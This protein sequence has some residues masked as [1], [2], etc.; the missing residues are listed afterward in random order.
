MRGS[1]TMERVVLGAV[2]SFL[3][4]LAV[5]HLLEPEFD[6]SFH[7][8]SEYELGRFGWVMSL[9]FLSLGVAVVAMLRST[10]QPSTTRSGSVGRWWFAA[11]AV[12]FL[13]A[14]VF[15]PYRPTTWV[16]IIH[17]I[18]G[19]VIIDTFPIAATAYAASLRRAEGWNG[20]RTILKWATVLVW[21]GLILYTGSAIVLTLLSGTATRTTA[22]LLVGWPNRFMIVTYALWLVAAVWPAGSRRASEQPPAG[23][24]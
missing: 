6:P 13:G 14:G 10:W 16:S 15:Y 17:G 7:L 21:G 12:A 18:C 23:V 22:D 8:I 1:R 2:I 5:L 24:R 20:S 9:A 3:V 11:I 4:L 19:L